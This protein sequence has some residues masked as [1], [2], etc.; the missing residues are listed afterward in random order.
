[1]PGGLN[2]YYL[3]I[4]PRTERALVRSQ[5]TVALSKLSNIPQH[6]TTSTN[7]LVV[8]SGRLSLSTPNTGTFHIEDGKVTCANDLVTTVAL[9]GDVIHS[10]VRC[11][12]R[13][14]TTKV[15]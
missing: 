9:P 2:T 15:V 6:C 1:M 14:V 5:Q 11:T 4:A 12:G 7:Y 3:D 13:Y 8:I 10:A